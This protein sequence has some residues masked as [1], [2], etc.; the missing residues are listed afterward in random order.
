MTAV[1]AA[2]SAA[3]A[4]RQRPAGGHEGSARDALHEFFHRASFAASLLP[5]AT[6]LR[7]KAAEA[8][9]PWRF[10]RQTTTDRGEDAPNDEQYDDNQQNSLHDDLPA[11]A[12][13]TSIR[14]YL[15][16]ELGMR[17]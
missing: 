12:E 8:I 3:V 6:S 10:F 15:N 1:F 5:T 9:R 17:N 11:R 7:R 16:S 2:K 13:G 4:V 14:H